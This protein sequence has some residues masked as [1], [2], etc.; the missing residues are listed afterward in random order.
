M[1]NVILASIYTLMYMCMYAHTKQLPQK[2]TRS[3]EN[4][5][6]SNKK[7]TDTLTY[8]YIHTEM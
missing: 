5:L 7:Y 6:H 1:N 4:N 3:T 8:I 2:Q